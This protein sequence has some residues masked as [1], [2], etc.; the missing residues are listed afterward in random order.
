MS[1]HPEMERIVRLAQ[2]ARTLAQDDHIMVRVTGERMAVMLAD[3][4]FE[5]DPERAEVFSELAHSR[6]A[7]S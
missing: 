4:M 1:T 2:E 3:L 7:G 5:I 6:R